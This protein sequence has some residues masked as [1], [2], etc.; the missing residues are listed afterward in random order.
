MVVSL[1]M[2]SCTDLNETVY[3]YMQLSDVY[4]KVSDAEAACMGLYTGNLDTYYL[5][6]MLG[7]TTSTADTRYQN[8]VQGHYD[9]SFEHFNTYW[10]S[11]YETIRKANAVIDNLWSSPLKDEVKIPY[12]AEAMAM[13]SYAYLKLVKLWGDIPFRIAAKDVLQSDFKLTPMEQVYRQLISDMEWSITKIWKPMQKPRGRID[14]IGAKMILADI[15]LTCASSAR[16]YNPAT[17][18]KALKPYFIAFDAD[19]EFFWNR[20]KKL[21]SDVIASPYRLETANWTNLWGVDNRFNLEHIWS[22]QTIPGKIGTRLL[23]YTPT[24]AVGICEGQT[25]GGAFMTYDWAI[26]F[27]REDVRFKDG[28]IWEYIDGRNNPNKNGYYYV[29]LWRRDL[30]N[31]AAVLSGN[32]RTSNDTIFRYSSYQRLQTRKFYDQSYVSTNSAIGPA[33]QMPIYRT[34]EAYLFYAEAENELFSCTSDAV[35]KINFLRKRAGV[36]E[37]YPGQFSKDEFRAKILDERQWEFALEGKDIFDIMRMGVLEEECAFKE[38]L[39]DGKD[40]SANTNP[41]PRDADSYWLPYP[42]NET[43]VNNELKGILRMNYN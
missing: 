18:A 31:R 25:V 23:P 15:Y 26:S 3:S 39:W 7:S 43:S 10:T 2:I 37:Y 42:I 27:D 41:R 22:T 28:I 4:Q 17:S 21:C 16:A 40:L 30:N 6:V 33:I 1:L 11:Y 14:E 36:S 34:A 32:L 29:E 24:Y 19:K 5:T 9:K 38:V 12:I 20:V 13:R 35:E 8:V